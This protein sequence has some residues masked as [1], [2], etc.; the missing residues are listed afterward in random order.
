V[1]CI[2]L[3]I[4]GMKE[5]ICVWRSRINTPFILYVELARPRNINRDGNAL[6]VQNR[7]QS[8]LGSGERIQQRIH[9][10]A[11]SDKPFLAYTKCQSSH[12]L[13]V[14]TSL[15][16]TLLLHMSLSPTGFWQL[17]HYPS[18]RVPDNLSSTTPFLGTALF[19]SPHCAA[20]PCGAPLE[21]HLVRDAPNWL[22]QVPLHN[23]C[24]YC[25]M[26]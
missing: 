18:A 1:C 2:K 26:R 6:T 25:S 12:T 24:M 5:Q 21:T 3:L 20:P 13:E 16:S 22:D 11:D 9:A 14:M 19:H 7:F 4:C 8:R 15:W 10:G 17:I 23:G